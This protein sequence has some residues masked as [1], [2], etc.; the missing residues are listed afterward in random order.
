[1]LLLI[2]T[3]DSKRLFGI[4]GG[5][6]TEIENLP[7]QLAYLSNGKYRC[8]AS[9]ISKDFALTAGHCLLKYPLK[10]TLR[11][12]STYKNQGGILIKVKQS[13]FHPYFISTTFQNDFALLNFEKSINFTNLIQPVKLPT[14]D[15]IIYDGTSCT[16]AG[17]GKMENKKLSAEL[18]S[19]KVYIINQYVCQGNY[20]TS[21]VRLTI[22]REMICAGSYFGGSD[23]KIQFINFLTINSI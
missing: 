2:N 12:G 11:A 17:W 15:Q 9:L 18:K 5:T 4:V 7:Y 13:F 14:I 1:M 3:A 19:T 20:Y 16:V 23:G 10:L 21:L 6:R 8:G 22:T